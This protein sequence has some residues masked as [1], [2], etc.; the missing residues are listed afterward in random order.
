M[1]NIEHEGFLIGKL[2]GDKLDEAFEGSSPL[3]EKFRSLQKEYGKEFR[4][5][6]LEAL[7]KKDIKGTEKSLLRRRE[8]NKG[9]LE[10]AHS[11]YAELLGLNVKPLRRGAAAP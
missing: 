11:V 8:N 3:N 9:F 1:E 5:E 6:L 10:I 7:K 4:K 2:T